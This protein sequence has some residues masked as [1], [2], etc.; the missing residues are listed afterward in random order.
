MRAETRFDEDALVGT[1]WQPILLADRSQ[2]QQPF[3]L[4]ADLCN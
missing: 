3:D 4:S 1:P 2:R